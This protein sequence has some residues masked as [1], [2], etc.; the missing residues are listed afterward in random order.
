MSHSGPLNGLRVLAA[1]QLIAGPQCTKLLAAYG[2]DVIKL[3][4]PGVGDNA[5]RLG[6]LP[7]DVPYVDASGLFLHLNL[8]KRGMTLDVGGG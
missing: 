7:G 4:R 2:A 6:P 1:T 5:R 8:A 3:E